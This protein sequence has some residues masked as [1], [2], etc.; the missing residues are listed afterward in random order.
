MVFVPKHLRPLITNSNGKPLA[1]IE[2]STST[3]DLKLAKARYAE[4]RSSLE[5]EIQQRCGHLPA[6]AADTAHSTEL[7]QF[8][9]KRRLGEQFAALSQNTPKLLHSGELEARKQ[10][11]ESSVKAQ[12][13]S[14]SELKELIDFHKAVLH[15]LVE[16]FIRDS[17]LPLTT[18]DETE[19]VAAAMQ[20]LIAVVKQEHQA[21]TKLGVLHKPSSDAQQLLAHA[22]ASTPLRIEQLI[23]QAK[24]EWAEGTTRNY[25]GLVRR[26]MECIGDTSVNA[27]TTTNLNRFARYLNKAKKDGGRGYGKSAANDA[28]YRIRSLLSHYNAQLSE[29]QERI[30]LPNFDSIT[31]T[32]QDKKERRLKNRNLAISDANASAMARYGAKRGQPFLHLVVLLRLTG[33]RCSEVA[34]LRWCQWIERDDLPF[35]DLLDSKTPEGIRLVPINN[36]LKQYLL[37]YR[38]ASDHEQSDFILNNF[39]TKRKQPRHAI[40][41]FLRESKQAL[42][43]DGACNAHA[44]R[45]AVGGELGYSTREHI[46]M[47]ILG[48]EGGMTD[49]YTREDLHQLSEAM[50]VV[51][52]NFDIPH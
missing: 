4:I 3:S 28:A 30:N 38:P 22:T 25:Q 24:A 9:L 16:S 39:I 20:H 26:W 12:S 45:H 5:Q 32:Q 37:P 10:A 40:G 13:I 1:R 7:R 11:F 33:L 44:F 2:R 8:Q 36:K 18:T 29:Q 46:K 49:H 17:G 27:I 6:T 43:L 31:I 35:I 14:L 50:E 42:N 34:T 47:K 52:K 23:D 15:N 21:K 41:A 19:Q 51:G 48:H